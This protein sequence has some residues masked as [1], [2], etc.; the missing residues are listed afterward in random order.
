MGRF[1]LL[2]N[3]PDPPHQ[4]P[5]QHEDAAV[6]ASHARAERTES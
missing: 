4:D 6:P 1:L 3:V 2:V 5:R